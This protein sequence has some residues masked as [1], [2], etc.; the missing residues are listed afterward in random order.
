MKCPAC[1]KRACLFLEWAKGFTAITHVCPHCG[2]ALRASRRTWIV[3][4]AIFAAIPLVIHT[5]DSI[6]DRFGIVD[7]APRVGVYALVLMAI[8]GPVLFVEWRTGSYRI[9]E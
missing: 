6:S 5:A 2:Q 4:G 8:L 9:L 7:P 3:R 1:Q